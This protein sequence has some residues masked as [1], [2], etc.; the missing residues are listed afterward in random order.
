MNSLQT[1]V[2]SYDLVSKADYDNAISN[3]IN[4][5]NNTVKQGAM[6]VCSLAAEMKNKGMISSIHEY[7][8]SQHGIKRQQAYQYEKVADTFLDENG[9][10]KNDKIEQFGFSALDRIS[11]G[12]SKERA[13]EVIEH[14]TV[15]PDMTNKEIQA[16]MTE[17]KKADERK[18]PYVIPVMDMRKKPRNYNPD[19]DFKDTEK[20]NTVELIAGNYP[21]FY[22]KS[23]YEG[24]TKW[25]LI[26]NYDSYLGWGEDVSITVSVVN[27][28]TA[29]VTLINYA[30]GEVIVLKY[31]SLPTEF[32]EIL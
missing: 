24:H 22:R 25:A 31:Y 15:R 13:L 4:H 5:V 17:I 12:V 23:E 2:N 32:G 30:T 3:V 21:D 10:P 1:I 9:K 29:I 20:W 19:S 6:I 14:N 28:D 8:I 11:R 18:E 26:A 7:M 27:D 16:R